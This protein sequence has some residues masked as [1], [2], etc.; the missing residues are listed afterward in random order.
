MR[1]TTSHIAL[2]VG[3]LI[4]VASCARLHD[5]SGDSK[6]KVEYWYLAGANAPVPLSVTLFNE[7]QDSIE[8]VPV[9]IPWKEHEKKVLTAILSGNPPDLINM[10]TPISKWASRMALMPMDSLLVGADVGE[11]DFFAANWKDVTHQ[12]R[13]FG[14]PMYTASYAFFYNKAHFKEVGLDPGRPPRTWSELQTMAKR[15]DMRD[16][17]GRIRRLG[18][19]PDYGNLHMPMLMAWQNGAEFVRADTVVMMHHQ[20]LLDALA[21][22]QQFYS[23]YGLD[24]ILGF[25]AGLGMADQHGF[26]SGRLSMMVLDNTFI[27]QLERYAPTLEYGVSM[28]PT[29]EGRETAG[30]TGT[31]W[32]GIPRGAKNAEAAWAFLQFATSEECQTYEALTM[33]ENL[34]PANRL[35]LESS[36][37]LKVHPTR[38]VFVDMLAYAVSPVVVPMAHDVFWRE[39]TVAREQTFY[40]RQS[41]ETA[42]TMA[43]IRV[44]RELRE[45][46]AYDSYVRA[47]MDIDGFTVRRQ[48]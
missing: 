33:K 10:V 48:R 17:S 27:D 2:I 38:E 1:A 42:F 25:R 47:N 19:L 8:I 46:L 44:Q 18:F 28:I 21:W 24:Q 16:E 45:A 7:R 6:V 11:T 40:G 15:L 4:L 3:S 39:Y 23:D 14:L 43:S 35:T 13:V 5:S 36:D 22:I 37:F 31:W 34:F 29:W 20:A 9:A 32:V 41:P 12:G 30:S 26:I